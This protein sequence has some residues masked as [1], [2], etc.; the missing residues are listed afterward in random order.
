VTPKFRVWLKKEGNMAA[1]GDM[2]FKDGELYFIRL[3]QIAPITY[4]TS[5]NRV[6]KYKSEDVVLM[7]STGLKDCNDR[8]IYEG[9]VLKVSD[10]LYEI[11]EENPLVVVKWDEEAGGYTMKDFTG[12]F[13]ALNIGWQIA[14]KFVRVEVVGNIYENPELLEEAEK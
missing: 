8:E 14:D 13:D 12:E 7:Q 6:P 1:I 3:E 11:D 4:G 9:D 5:W 10:G 2:H